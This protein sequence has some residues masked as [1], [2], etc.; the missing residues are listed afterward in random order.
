MSYN[1]CLEFF[2]PCPRGLEGALSAELCELSTVAADPMFVVQPPMAGGVPFIGTCAAAITANL[3]SRIA[4]R[5]LLKIAARLYRDENDIY[6][7]A[8][9]QPWEQWFIASYTLRVNV[10]A[11]RSPLRSLDF[12]MLRIK[13]AICD[14]LRERTGARPNIDTNQPD[15]RIQAF[16][17]ATRC[18]LYIDTSGEPLFKRGWRLNKGT[19]PLRENLAAGILRLSGWT[20]GMPLFDPMCGSGTYIAEAAQIALGIAPGVG[21]CFGFEKLQQFDIRTWQHLK[22]QAL[23]TRQEA[24]AYNI[25]RGDLLI[26]GSD[27]SN[28]MLAKASANLQRAGV[29]MVPLKQCDARDIV[30]PCN[31]PGVIVVNPPYGERINVRGRNAST[32][33]IKATRFQRARPHNVDSAFFYSFGYVLKQRFPGWRAFILSADRTL[34]GQMRLRES[35]KT[36]LYNGA[37][38]CRLFCFNLVAGAICSGLESSSQIG[39]L[40]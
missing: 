35:T 19:A 30:A 8:R 37:L 3:Y 11:I 39:P 23:N 15:V 5:V 33:N 31:A 28:D 40:N 9:E 2:A 22:A 21:R 4:N 10:T 18:T 29:P 1:T 12:T 34:P 38:E 20:P 6:A 36:L 17:D 32:R 14:R 25:E 7:L 16:I 27:V 13:D 26:Y 24:A